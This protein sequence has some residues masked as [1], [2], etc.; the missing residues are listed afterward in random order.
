MQ[1][2]LEGGVFVEVKAASVGAG[3]GGKESDERGRDGDH[4]HA[5]DADVEAILGGNGGERHDCR[6]NGRAGDAEL[7]GNGCHGAGALGANAFSER[8]VG[9]DGH[10]G[11][12]DVA[13][14]DEDGE[15]EGAEGC[16]DG[17]VCGMASEQAFGNLYEPVHASRCVQ[18]ACTGDGGDNDIDDISGRGAGF[19]A[20]AQDEDGEGDAR[21]GAQGQTAIAGA[22]VES[23]EDDEELQ[24]EHK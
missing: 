19:Q 1:P 4:E 8:D 22:D 3:T 5:W 24:Q 14:S 2:L 21:D 9:D 11:I 6:S 17:D 7:R 18:H 10:E 12:D 15:E 13:R 23:S 16:E 20:E